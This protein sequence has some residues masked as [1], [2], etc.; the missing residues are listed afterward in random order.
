MPIYE[1][2]LD[3]LVATKVAAGRLTFTPDLA[4]SVAGA[5]AL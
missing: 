4:A 3:T 5:D 2:G 1:P